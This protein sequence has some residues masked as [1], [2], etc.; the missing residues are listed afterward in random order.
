MVNM[1]TVSDQIIER[2]KK[3]AKRV[4]YILIL[5]TA[6]SENMRNIRTGE[7]VAQS[8][9]RRDGSKRHVSGY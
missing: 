6:E 5:V 2:I 3:S 4:K 1:C 9:V 7:E 8:V